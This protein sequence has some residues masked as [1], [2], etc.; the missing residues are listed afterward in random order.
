[1]A[2]QHDPRP[3]PS[4]GHLESRRRVG[5]FAAEVFEDLTTEQLE[6]VED[7]LFRFTRTVADTPSLRAA[8]ADRDLP[9]EE[10]LGIVRD[11]LAGKVERATLRLVEYVVIGGRSRDIVRD[12]RLA[13]LRSPPAPAARRVAQVRAAQTVER[14][15]GASACH[16]R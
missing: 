2:E 7:Q 4:L 10:R 3:C 5:G 14:D 6:E 12:P 16:A 9:P 11:L 8:L 1:M 15:E 13:G